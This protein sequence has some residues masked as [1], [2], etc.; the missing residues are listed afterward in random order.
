MV[1]C[2]VL[3]LGLLALA[4]EFFLPRQLRSPP[5][6]RL[7]VSPAVMCSTGDQGPSLIQHFYARHFTDTML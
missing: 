7:P 5:A 1:W 2:P 4:C 3:P 6:S